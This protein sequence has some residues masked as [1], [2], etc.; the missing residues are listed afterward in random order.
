MAEGLLELY[1][2]KLSLN[3]LSAY[4]RELNVEARMPAISRP[5]RVVEIGDMKHPLSVFGGYQGGKR[6][7][8]TFLKRRTVAI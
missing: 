5:A 7:H 8:G 6:H 4:A 1:T 3:V 2:P